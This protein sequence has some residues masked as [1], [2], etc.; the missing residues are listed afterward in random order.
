MG[1]SL[2][3]R[4]I[5]PVW[6]GVLAGLAYG[7]VMQLMARI[8]SEDSKVLMTL[9]YIFVL[10]LAMGSLTLILAG[11]E[12]RE[13]WAYRIMMPWLTT[14]LSMVV[15][16]IWQWEGSICLILG[17]PV[18]LTLSSIGGILAAIVLT[19]NRDPKLKL[20]FALLIVA[21]PPIMGETEIRLPL[22]TEHFHTATFIDI[23]ADSQTVWK[24]I[25]RVPKI[26]ENQ[27]G[28]FYRLGFP[29][30][31]EATLSA[32]RVG[33]VRQASFER[34]LVFIETVHEWKPMR[35]IAFHIQVD[36]RATPLD[37]LDEHVTVGGRYFD[38]LNGRYEMETLPTGKIR[39]HLSSDHRL[40][41]SFNWYASL[42]SK[43]LMRDIQSSILDVIKL[44]CENNP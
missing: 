23:N 15:A 14:A 29:K 7:I 38:V 34:G 24:N 10:P 32:E 5:R 13:S 35:S 27:R 42:W 12:Q 31:V 43:F 28:F 19:S 25:I 30:P 21:I 2:F 4:F 36:P 17:L 3:L 20:S 6:P 37:T 40:S 11:A 41:T 9:G 33:G 16:Y 1:N 18:Y 44:R 39:L 26:T 22:P 8:G